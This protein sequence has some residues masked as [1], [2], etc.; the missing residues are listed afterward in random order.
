M[1]ISPARTSAF[2]ILI[3]IETEHLYSS[4]LLAKHEPELSAVDRGLCHELVLGVLRRKLLLDRYID[5]FTS[6][7]KLDI[8]IRVALQLGIFQLYYLD[9]VPDHAAVN[10]SV[11]LT[12]R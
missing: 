8:E 4:A 6:G 5:I 3:K 1:R 9:R 12:Q 7:K 2:D 11:G 10:E